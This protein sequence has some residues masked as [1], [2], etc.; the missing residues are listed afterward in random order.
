MTAT[1]PQLRR[2]GSS[3]LE[4]RDRRLGHVLPEIGVVSEEQLGPALLQ[5]FE[6]VE[7]R[8][9]LLAVI[10]K[11]RQATLAQGAA[12][13]AGV[14]RQHDL[15]LVGAHLEGLVARRVAVGGN[16][17]HAAVAEQVV[18]ALDLLHR[19]AVVEVGLEEADLGR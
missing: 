7:R 11:A 16:A 6:T 18:L 2:G 8:Q 15:A 4:R 14:A 9:H 17:Y 3:T 5:R 10:D 12:E 1:P 13:V 19:M